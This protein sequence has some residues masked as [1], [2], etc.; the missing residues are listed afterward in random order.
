MTWT[1]IFCFVYADFTGHKVVTPTRRIDG[2]ASERA[3]VKAGRQLNGGTG[4][5]NFS[6]IEAPSA[7]VEQ[8]FDSAK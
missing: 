4:Y 2:Y 6:C 5:V 3:C 1:L 8:E 7:A